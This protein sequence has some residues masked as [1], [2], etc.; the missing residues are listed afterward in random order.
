MPRALVV[1]DDDIIRD[2][3]IYKLQRMGLDVSYAEDGEDGLEQARSGDFD[4]LLLDLMMPRMSGI[5]LCRALRADG[6]T[7]PILMMTGK[8]LETD[9]EAGFA[10]GA[11]DY[12]LKPISVLELGSRVSRQLRRAGV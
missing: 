5:D 7:T 8:V 12:M 6:D 9:V 11:D 1:E 3:V 2:L 4:V 10:A